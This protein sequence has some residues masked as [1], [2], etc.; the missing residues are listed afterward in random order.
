MHISHLKVYLAWEWGVMG[1]EF[2]CVV[3]EMFWEWIEGMIV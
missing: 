2:W 1:S 3:R